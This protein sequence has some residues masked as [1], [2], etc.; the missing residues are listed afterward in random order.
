MGEVREGPRRGQ[1]GAREEPGRDQGGTR[2]GPGRGQ[3]VPKMQPLKPKY[4]THR[5]IF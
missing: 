4:N 5:R 3:R 1:G 2:E